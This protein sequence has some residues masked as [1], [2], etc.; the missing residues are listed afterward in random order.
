MIG[1][2]ATEDIWKAQAKDYR[3]LHLATHGVLNSVRPMYS[4]L[5]LSYDGGSGREDG[6][7]EAWEIMR[8]R[9]NAEMVV[10]SACESG[11]GKISAGEGIIGLSW[12]F[13]VAGVPTTVVSQW[14]VESRST[15]K[16]M[17]YFYGNLNRQQSKS[18]ALHQAMLAILHNPT[19]K[20]PFY[21][22]GFVVLGKS[23]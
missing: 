8:S 17:T 12:A 15:A 2:N 11:R 22:A 21:W 16:L 23:Q 10:M 20:H 13:F 3:F 18:K 6:V 1:P 4:H 19:T 14:N 9:L 5:L 7:L